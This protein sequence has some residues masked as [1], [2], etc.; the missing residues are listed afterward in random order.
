MNLLQILW[1]FL[2]V[3][4]KQILN[5]YENSKIS[6][7]ESYFYKYSSYT[8]KKYQFIGYSG[9]PKY[10]GYIYIRASYNDLYELLNT[11]LPA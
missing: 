9:K 2:I 6:Y 1:I 8:S 11:E 3:S 10:I 4:I 5:N 7:G